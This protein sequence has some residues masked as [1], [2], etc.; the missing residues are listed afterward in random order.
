MTKQIKNTYSKSYGHKFTGQN[1]DTFYINDLQSYLKE[2]L[3]YLIARVLDNNS[4]M[5]PT[6]KIHQ[7]FQS[8][9]EFLNKNHR[10]ET[11][12]IM[13]G[14]K[15]Y[16][17]PA[18]KF[19]IGRNLFTWYHMSTYGQHFS[20]V[21]GLRPSSF[22]DRFLYSQSQFCSKQITNYKLIKLN[23]QLR[24]QQHFESTFRFD[25]GNTVVAYL[26]SV[27]KENQ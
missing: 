13:A 7:L 5:Y 23:K 4:F 17:R 15:V 22:S 9:V 1:G 8:K 19:V 12:R 3:L 21:C 10:N 16:Q 24:Y 2:F 26:E 18:D 27:Q 25:I 6:K 11:M 14:F 20:L